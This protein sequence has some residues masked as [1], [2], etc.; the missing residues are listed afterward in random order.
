VTASQ[1]QLVRHLLGPRC[2]RHLSELHIELIEVILE[3][4][5]DRPLG[6]W[7]TRQ[8]LWWRCEYGGPPEPNDE[9]GTMNDEGKHLATGH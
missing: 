7:A 4:S 8:L 1:L 2:R 5:A 3:R 9:R 6:E